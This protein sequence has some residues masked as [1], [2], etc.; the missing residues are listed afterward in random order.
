MALSLKSDVLVT[1]DSERRD[2][3]KRVPQ[4]SITVIVRPLQKYELRKFLYN[5]REL[6]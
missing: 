2:R 3:W 6:F 5:T 1:A 4:E